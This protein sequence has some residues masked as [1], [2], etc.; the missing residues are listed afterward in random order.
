MKEKGQKQHCWLFGGRLGE[1][2]RIGGS[3]MEVYKAREFEGLGGIS[4]VKAGRSR[5]GKAQQRTL[6]K[7]RDNVIWKIIK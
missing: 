4:S 5:E 3:Y 1:G 2:E 7:K 6:D